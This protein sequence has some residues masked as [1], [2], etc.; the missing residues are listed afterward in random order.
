[1]QQYNLLYNTI[2]R[3]YFLCN[4]L[5]LWLQG[6]WQQTKDNIICTLKTNLR[7]LKQQNRNFGKRMM[8][9]LSWR[10]FKSFCVHE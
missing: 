5:L 3:L 2:V 7:M 10:M 8:D 6:G 4:T 1:M 9:F